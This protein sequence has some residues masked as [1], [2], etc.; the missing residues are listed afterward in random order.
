MYERL[1]NKAIVPDEVVIQ[2]HLGQ[3]SYCCLVTFENWLK[4]N[5]H[6][7]RELKFPFGNNYG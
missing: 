1:L 2:G 4:S 3:Q 5:Y 7:V 6:L